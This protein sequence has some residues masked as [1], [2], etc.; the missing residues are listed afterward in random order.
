MDGPWRSHTAVALQQLGRPTEARPLVEEELQI[1][2]AWGAPGTLARSLHA[3]AL[4]DPDAAVSHLREAAAIVEPSPAR[5]EAAK[6]SATLGS[7]LRR[8]GQLS[9]ARQPLRQAIELAMACGAASLEEHTRAE[10][11]A[12]G[13]RPRPTTLTGLSSLTASERRVAELAAR[14]VG[15]REIAQALFVTTKTVESHLSSVY[16]KL[17]VRTRHDLPAA[18]AVDG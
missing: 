13:G 6:S 3:M 17:G 11:S 12:A 5:L 10:L 1:A 2:R 7:A 4:V 15:N 9:E 8:A 16:R 18:L 14:A